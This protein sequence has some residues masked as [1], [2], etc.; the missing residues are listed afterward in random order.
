MRRAYLTYPAHPGILKVAHLT[1]P[2]ILGYFEGCSSSIPDISG[3]F[4]TR[5]SDIPC[6]PENF[7]RSYPDGI[8]PGC[9]SC[10]PDDRWNSAYCDGTLA[11]TTIGRSRR[12]MPAIQ[13]NAGADVDRDN[14]HRR[15]FS[16]VTHPTLS[17]HDDKQPKQQAHCIPVGAKLNAMPKCGSGR[18]SCSLGTHPRVY[19]WPC[20]RVKFPTA[21]LPR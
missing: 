7:R 12:P 3:Y 18:A 4:E 2:D 11:T 21:R 5:I 19:Q 14:R 13:S 6:A 9:R 8:R 1:Y 15:C 20:Y 10:H 16:A 17:N